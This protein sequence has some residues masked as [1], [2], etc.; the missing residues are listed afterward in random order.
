M[1][2]LPEFVTLGA[3]YLSREERF[4]SARGDMR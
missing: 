2:E 1:F 4:Q 3:G